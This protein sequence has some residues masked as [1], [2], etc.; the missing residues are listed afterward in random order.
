M[1]PTGHFF[2][3]FSVSYKGIHIEK[4]FA[5]VEKQLAEDT[6]ISSGL[7]ASIEVLIFLVASLLGAKMTNST[8]SSLPPSQDPNRSKE[9]KKGTGKKR[10]GQKGRKGVRLE[11]VEHPDEEVFLT[12]DTDLLPKGHTYSAG[13]PETRQV[14]D[15]IIQ[16][17]V[18]QYSA[19][20]W[21]DENGKKY[22]APFPKN[23]QQPTQYG[24]G[25][26]SHAVYLSTY[27]LLPTQR[28]SEYFSDKLGLDVSEGSL[29][30]WNR[31]AGE[32]L[33]F[34]RFEEVLKTKLQESE[35]L[36]LDETGFKRGGK[37]HWLHV[38][39]NSDWTYLYS[40]PKRGKEAM[41]AMGVLEKYTGVMIHDHWKPYYSYRDKIHSLCNAHHLRE[42]QGV[43][44]KEEE[45][46]WAK[47]MKELLI[48]TKISTET[49]G[50]VLRRE[51]QKKVR[52]QYR[53]ILHT[54]ETECPPPKE[55]KLDPDGKK[56][57]GKVKKTK[58]RNLLERLRDFEDDTLRFVTQQ[59]IPFTNNLGERDLRM[60][61]VKQKIS[62]CFQSEQAAQ[63][64]AL[65]R[66]Y[67]GSAKKQNLSPSTVLNL[68][69]EGK[70]FCGG[71]G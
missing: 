62:G 66:S 15:I 3:F 58:A 7:K 63:N 36:H 64:F 50:G 17:N 5:S 32:R 42:L 60:T 4:L 46:Q 41:D 18:I 2:P 1:S 8:N 31:E 25:V 61:K 57:R 6:S 68:L 22:T 20:V 39:S 65:I 44:D 49:S 28:I 54:A 59:N 45:H 70:I 37:G 35:Y 27:Q 56:A 38:A 51:D 52:K 10:G 53:E 69:F 43:V 19:Q 9:E 16:R 13:E 23:V 26:K 14:F 40:H 47:N 30:N 71:D 34:L 21:V 48:Q 11:K 67:I 33:R 24:E 55:K 12:L 29:C